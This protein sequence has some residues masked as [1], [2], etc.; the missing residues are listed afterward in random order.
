MPIGSQLRIQDRK[1]LDYFKLAI[2]LTTCIVTGSSRAPDGGGQP[3]CDCPTADSY[4]NTSGC[5]VSIISIVKEDADCSPT[6]H[7]IG[8]SCYAEVTYTLGAPCT[9]GPWTLK[10]TTPCD[11]ADAEARRHNGGAMTV[12]VV[13]G[14]CWPNPN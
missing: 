1:V 9:T 13:C 5:S 11:S 7:T 4:Q 3:Y 2:L 6:C 10:P 14:N 8:D 12:T